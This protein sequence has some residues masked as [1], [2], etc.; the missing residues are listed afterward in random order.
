MRIKAIQ[1]RELKYLLPWAQYQE[2]VDHL[3]TKLTPDAHHDGSYTVTSLYFDTA[4][5]KAYRDKIDGQRYRRKLRMRIY[6]KETTSADAPCF[7]EIKQRL[8][9]TISKRRLLLPYETA[10]ALETYENL[11]GDANPGD[12][13]VL[14]E[15]IYLQTCSSYNRPVLS[16]TSVWL[17]TAALMNPTCRV[18]FDTKLKGRIHE[19]SLSSPAEN[20]YFAPPDWCIM[21]VKVNERVPYWLTK[22][23]ATYGI[24]LRRI[25]KYCATLEANHALLNRQRIIARRFPKTNQTAGKE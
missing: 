7:V 4:D 13:A 15:V 19:L 1:R 6:G 22:M 23:T 11:L 20:H 21:E 14:E 9:K 24:S 25:S 18:T 2:V 3:T 16:A 12:R 8:N 10:T 5:Y 17:S